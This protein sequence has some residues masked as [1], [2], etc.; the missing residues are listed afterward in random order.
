[1]Y[2][3]IVSSIS[4]TTRLHSKTVSVNTLLDMVIDEYDHLVLQDPSKTK[5]K[6]EDV[7]FNANTSKKGKGKK[8]H[9]NGTATI[10][11]SPVTEI[12]TAGMKEEARRDR[13]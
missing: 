5:T 11:D 12:W 3:H 6:S 8:K 9:F 1:M 13:P 7:A 2:N 4:A 10:V